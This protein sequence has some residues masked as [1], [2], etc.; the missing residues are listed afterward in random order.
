MTTETAIKIL[1]NKNDKNIRVFDFTYEIIT[2]GSG[3][4]HSNI[5]NKSNLSKDRVVSEGT[6]E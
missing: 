4:E 5:A 6:Y 3:D 2:V 1:Y